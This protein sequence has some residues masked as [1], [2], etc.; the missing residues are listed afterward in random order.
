MDKKTVGVVLLGAALMLGI[1]KVF[2]AEAAKTPEP[3]SII[4]AKPTAETLLEI[5]ADGKKFTWKG[6]KN[7][8]VRVLLSEIGTR[9]QVIVG[10]QQELAAARKAAE[11]CT[12]AAKKAKKAK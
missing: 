9:G 6:D 10:L 4:I 5:S 2:G 1:V 8:V 3:A 7:E 12:P 11:A